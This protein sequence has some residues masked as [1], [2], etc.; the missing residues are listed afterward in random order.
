MMSRGARVAT[1][2]VLAVTGCR[3]PPERA[4]VAEAPGI[5]DRVQGIAAVAPAL[6]DAPV[7]SNDAGTG[8]GATA[9]AQD[10]ATIS[11]EAAAAPALPALVW[12][13]GDRASLPPQDAHFLEL[14][15]PLFGDFHLVAFRV[16]P[17]QTAELGP[18][19][20]AE[21]PFGGRTLHRL[22]VSATQ[23]PTSTGALD[24]TFWKSDDDLYYVRTFG[25]CVAASDFLYGPFRAQGDTFAFA[26][27]AR[28]A[29]PPADGGSVP[30]CTASKTTWCPPVPGDRCGGH[31]DADSCAADSRCVVRP[32]YDDSL[33]PCG[34][35]DFACRSPGCPAIGC[36]ARCNQ[37]ATEA[38]C[39]A[40]APRCS[41]A[42]GSAQRCYSDWGDCAWL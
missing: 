18:R 3:R 5:A 21:I 41:W 17:E 13:E 6:P 38:E 28:T 29:A 14:I 12:K 34:E 35:I 9:P 40:Q 24:V 16:P 25:G 19:D 31:Q 4:D 10:G 1:L 32:F 8:G 36:A 20:A 11:D 39:T 30:P 33:R 15:V 2:V 37:L 26:R 23:D 7:P 42:G 27:D 22:P